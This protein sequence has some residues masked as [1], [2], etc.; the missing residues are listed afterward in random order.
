MLRTE[1]VG[2]LSD[3]VYERL[4]PGWR[5]RI[6]RALC[7]SLAREMPCLEF[8]QVCIFVAQWTRSLPG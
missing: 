3:A 4:L 1:S 5:M 7:R 8:L 6:R 2:L